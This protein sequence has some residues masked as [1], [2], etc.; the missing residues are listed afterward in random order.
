MW[1]SNGQLKAIQ[2]FIEGKED[3][4]SINYNCDNSISFKGF[5]KQGELTYDYKREIE[6]GTMLT[7][8][9]EFI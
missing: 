9:P 6:R 1:Y 7:F 8:K 4:E 2:N 3:G 5:Y